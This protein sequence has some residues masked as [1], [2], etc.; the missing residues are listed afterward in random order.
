[1]GRIRDMSVLAELDHRGLRRPSHEDD[2]CR[3]EKSYHQRLLACHASTGAVVIS[4]M[5]LPEGGCE[6]TNVSAATSNL[7]RVRLRIAIDSGS[8]PMRYL[9]NL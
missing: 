2:Q 6:H 7:A 4:A 3:R 9:Q 8:K 1:M 5:I